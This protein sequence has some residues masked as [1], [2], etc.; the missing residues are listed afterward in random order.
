MCPTCAIASDRTYDLPLEQGG[1]VHGR[2][3]YAETGTPVILPLSYELAYPPGSY[4]N[5]T[6]EH[7]ARSQARQ[8]TGEFTISGLP[9]G[10]VEGQ[11]A[12]EADLDEINDP[13]F[14]VRYPFQDGTPY[15][16]TSDQKSVTVTT[17]TDLDLGD[18]ELTVQQ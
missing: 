12:Q 14:F 9:A 16:L 10:D 3:V 18:I 8:S 5:P 1:T 11:L 13:W 2:L 6:G 7:P 15:Y 17:G 4:R